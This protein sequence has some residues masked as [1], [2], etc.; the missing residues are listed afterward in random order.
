[1]VETQRI[2]NYRVIQ[3]NSQI[4][5]KDVDD[6]VV[7]NQHRVS[8]SSHIGTYT[9]RYTRFGYGTSRS[10]GVSVGDV[11]F[12]YQGRP[13][14]VFRQITDPNGVARLAKSARKQLL[15]AIK[16]TEKLQAQSRKQVIKA[17]KRKVEEDVSVNNITVNNTTLDCPRCSCTNPKGSKYCNNCGFRIDNKITDMVEDNII[18]LR[19]LLKASPRFIQIVIMHL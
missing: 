5:L 17:T 6:I 18:L 7:M 2:T 19:Q 16:A 13:Y 9:G 1:V 4:S 12:M 11:V 8:Q 3:N 14:I 10:T 15:A